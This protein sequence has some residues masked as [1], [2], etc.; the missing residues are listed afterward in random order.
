MKLIKILR[1]ITV[2][3][4]NIR[5][6]P[7][8]DN[9]GTI[10]VGNYEGEY[11]VLHFNR[12]SEVIEIFLNDEVYKLVPPEQRENDQYYPEEESKVVCNKFLKYFKPYDGKIEVDEYGVSRIIVPYNKFKKLI[13]YKSEIEYLGNGV[14]Q[15]KDK[16]IK[17]VRTPENDGEGTF[18]KC[19]IIY[20]EDGKKIGDN[21][22]ANG[23]IDSYA[24]F[25]TGSKYGQKQILPYFAVR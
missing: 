13:N 4:P 19:F 17:F 1:E 9:S 12:D 24:R 11:H 16:K 8:D 20:N 6:E 2:N 21:F 10:Y 7:E 18:E 14:F 15:F 3:N 25:L 23:E 5:F 22:T